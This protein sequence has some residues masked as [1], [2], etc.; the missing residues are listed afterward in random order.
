MPEAILHANNADT[1]AA[2]VE[3]ALGGKVTLAKETNYFYA[4]YSIHAKN[5]GILKSINY[6]GDIQNKIIDEK[7]FVS[8]GD[9]VKRFDMGSLML[10]NLILQFDT[11]TEMLST[12]DKMDD[13]IK[14]N[15]A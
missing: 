1:I 7:M 12:I 11:Y 9:D 3:V 6:I 5:D 4:T 14:V 2:T 15:V 10:G 13:Y 8:P